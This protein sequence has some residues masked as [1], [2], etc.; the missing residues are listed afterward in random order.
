MTHKRIEYDP[1]AVRRMRQRGFTRQDVRTVLALG[2]RAAEAYRE[3]AAPRY[4]KRLP[5]RGR[6][7]VVI[8]LEDA[9]RIYVITVEWA[10]D[11]PGR[12]D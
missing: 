11:P 8:Y 4:S 2:A 1:H 7:A 3:G 6:D 9:H 5:L 10:G 12:D